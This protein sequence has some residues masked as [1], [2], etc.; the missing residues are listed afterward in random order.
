[1]LSKIY[2]FD[3]EFERTGEARCSIYH[4]GDR[5]LHKYAAENALDYAGTLSPVDGRTIIMV[6]AMSAGEYYG[7]NR[8]G[9]AWS[10]RPVMVGNQWAVAAGETLPDHHKTFEDHAT[11]YK[12]HI[13]QDPS[14]NYGDVLKSFYNWKMHRVELFLSI[15][16]MKACDIIGRIDAGEHP[17]VSMGCR[18]PYDVC[19]IC[20]HQAPTTSDYCHHVNGLD[21]RFG[22]NM[23]T[24]DG[25]RCY[26]WNPCPDLFD[27]SFVF[28]QAD[29]IATMMKKVAGYDPYVIQTS[30][31]LGARVEDLAEKR[32]AIQK[33]SDI[34]KIIEGGI[35]DPRSTPSMPADEQAATSNLVEAL[36]PAMQDTPTL[37]MQDTAS[38][39]HCSLP[40]F[41]NS[42]FQMGMMPTV[43]ELFRFICAQ[44]GHE[45]DPQTEQRLAQSQGKVAALLAS[46][47]QIISQ[48][49]SLGL[50]KIGAEHARTDVMTVLEPLQEKRALWKEY[51]ARKYVPES[52]GNLAGATGVVDAEDAYY[53]PQWQS[54][55]WQDPDSG[56]TYETTRRAAERADVSNKKKE[57]AE[58]AGLAGGLGVA[59]KALTHR[60]PRAA[61][62][63]AL[64]AGG[65]MKWMSD[66]QE[67][68]TVKTRE[69]VDV[70][71]NVEFVEKRS[72]FRMPDGSA[73]KR[74]GTPL[75]GG[76]LLTAALLSDRAAAAAPPE[77]HRALQWAHDNP[78]GAWLGGTTA[79]SGLQHTLDSVKPIL[80]HAAYGDPSALD[81]VDV[82]ALFLQIG[83]ALLR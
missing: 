57:Y 1:M 17:G 42:F 53:T 22:M 49:D 29:P 5:H 69:G 25:Q 35:V 4:P 36:R 61:A 44:A 9:D 79:L 6:L 77:A 37:S 19:S 71:L 32:A 12:H 55:H 60:V 8:N 58:L 31:S 45:S 59:Y 74:V 64:G 46:T 27:I 72:G 40:E 7:P 66:V 47:P 43:V 18:I 75:A 81:P 41:S 62:P 82:G 13:N 24:P 78:Y 28:R 54:L 73:L 65:A 2:Q 11:V 16:N 14:N 83:T 50:L 23:L 10:E 38:V 52:I 51:V 30:A 63:L 68:P 56:K 48:L 34:D 21:P 26:V 39:S 67:M 76:A 80:K 15:D 3:G 70:P 33:I 20:G